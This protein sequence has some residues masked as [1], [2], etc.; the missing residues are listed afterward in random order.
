MELQEKTKIMKKTVIITSLLIALASC[1]KSSTEEAVVTP[2]SLN[3]TGVWKN[4][5]YYDDV[6]N[7]NGTNPSDNF[8]PIPN[9]ITTTFYS[10][11]YSSTYLGNPYQNGIY[12]IS[13]DSILSQDGTVKGKIAKL[14]SSE[15]IINNLSDLGGVKYVKIQNP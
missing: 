15:L 3:I 2:P 14:T 12:S 1:S 10:N 9:G 6:V 4:I 8:Y 11:T 7:P 5:G 13:N